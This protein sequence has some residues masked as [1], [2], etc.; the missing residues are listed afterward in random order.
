MYMRDSVT[1]LFP[2]LC[3]NPPLLKQAKQ[4]SKGFSIFSLK[5]MQTPFHTWA[6]K[7]PSNHTQCLKAFG[8][9]PKALAQLAF[10]NRFSNIYIYRYCIHIGLC[11]CLLSFHQPNI[12]STHKAKSPLAF[13]LK[14]ALARIHRSHIYTYGLCLC[15][16]PFT[17]LARIQSSCVVL[18][19]PS[20]LGFLSFSLPFIGRDMQGM[21]MCRNDICIYLEHLMCLLRP[22]FVNSLFIYF[23]NST[24]G[25]NEVCVLISL[26]GQTS[27]TSNNS[28]RKGLIIDLKWICSII[29]L[30]GSLHFKICCT[31][32]AFVC[33]I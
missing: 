32:K 29:D 25:R 26:Q 30:N 17:S 23:S 19:P 21:Y 20:R 31:M 16:R 10:T 7:H 13:H 3:Q 6:A 11:L 24:K 1:S 18:I 9:H 28:L 2:C 5:Q 4:A 27:A 22:R 33:I 12:L 8:F 14:K 15:Y